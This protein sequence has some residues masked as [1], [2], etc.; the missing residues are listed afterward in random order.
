MLRLAQS[1]AIDQAHRCRGILV[2][3]QSAGYSQVPPH[4]LDPEPF[5]LCL[6]CSMQLSLGGRQRHHLLVLGPHF[7]TAGSLMMTPAETD[8]RYALSPPQSASEEASTSPI[9]CQHF[10]LGLPTRYLPILLTHS[11][12]RIDG[13][14]ITQHTRIDANLRSGRSCDK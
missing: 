4:A 10:A 5:R 3:I 11:M 14:A 13:F 7:E 8:R 9:C 12:S 2:Q 1:P 6:D